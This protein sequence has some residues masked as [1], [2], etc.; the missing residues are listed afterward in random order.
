MSSKY[1]IEQ[2][3]AVI[4]DNDWEHDRHDLAEMVLDARAERDELKEE[5]ESLRLENGRLK[6]DDE[7]WEAIVKENETLRAENDDLA[8]ARFREHEAWTEEELEAAR[9]KRDRFQAAVAAMQGIIANND[10]SGNPPA[11][12]EMAVEMADALLAALAK[13]SDR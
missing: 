1:T 3:R 6:C 9:H 7:E 2:L 13:P 10:T 5:L 8:A 12:A 4:K 11:Y